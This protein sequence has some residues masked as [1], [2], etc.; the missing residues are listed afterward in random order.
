MERSKLLTDQQ[1]L[2][3]RKTVDEQIINVLVDHL[4]DL[5][6]DTSSE[7]FMVTPNQNKYYQNEAVKRFG[8][9]LKKIN[10]KIVAID[11]SEN[12]WWFQIGSM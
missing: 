12:K 10:K 3:R 7:R 6:N 4:I 8:L 11:E 1:K 5:Y 9:E 2:E